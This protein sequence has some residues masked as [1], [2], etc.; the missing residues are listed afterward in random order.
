MT[1]AGAA[2]PT[3]PMGRLLTILGLLATFGSLATDM[4]LPGFH[5]MAQYFQVPEGAIEVTLSVFFFGLT[6]G[7]AI[8]GPLIDRFG[9]RVPLLVG[10]ALYIV[11]TILCLV[12]ANIGLF[13]VLRFLQAVGG[14]AGQIVGRAI[15][16]DLFDA[17]ESAQA[18]SLLTIITMLAPIVAP[19]LGGFLI[20]FA[21]W[22]SVFVVMLLF[23]LLSAA[24]VWLFVPE[25]LP[26]Q[27]RQAES[28]LG[29]CSTWR[30]LITD[31]RFI[32][33]ALTGGLAQ[34]GMFAFITGSPFVFINLH[35]V[36]AQT[37]SWLFALVGCALVI[38]SQIN[39][40]ALRC[41]S[42]EF[43]LGAALILNAL[44][45][46]GTALAVPT[47]SLVA[48]LVLLW[49]AIGALGFIAANSAAIAMAAS[50]RHS[51]SG[52]SLV[53]VLQF[54]CAFIASSLV[55]AGQ[56]GTAYPMTVVIAGCGVMA[57]LLWLGVR[58]APKLG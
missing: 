56:N 50:G 58:R 31:S 12:T 53:G 44:T 15:V 43:L 29:I 26:P 52:S 4:Y 33:P 3:L 28:L 49:F 38:F 45:G 24:L 7:Q 25:T 41:R 11:T 42:P 32:V 6:I 54:G 48:L 14:S 46:I 36:S 8:Y 23:G 1:D 34:A 51:G 27:R 40:V 19:I 30:S 57:T 2:T 18:L 20:T 55:A 10:I 5:L 35:G 17:R 9:R 16:N 22:K 13:I 21:G 47:G 39:R 37:Y